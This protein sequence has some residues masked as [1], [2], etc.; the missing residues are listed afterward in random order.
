[1]ASLTLWT[2]VWISSGNWW[3]T[4]KPGLLLPTGSQ[5]ADMTEWL[6]WSELKWFK[7]PQGCD[8][9]WASPRSIHIYYFPR[10]RTLLVSL[11]PI[12][13]WKFN[14]TQQWARALSIVPAGLVARIQDSHCH[15]QTSISGQ[16]TKSCF[17]LLQAEPGPKHMQVTFLGIIKI[18]EFPLSALGYFNSIFLKAYRYLTDIPCLFQY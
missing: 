1:M 13:M 2:W 12:S 3:W 8:Y 9:L 18:Y 4:G 16:E 6:N 7:L 10:I 11:L 14:S 5:R 17:K 15:S